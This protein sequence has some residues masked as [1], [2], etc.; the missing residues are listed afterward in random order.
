MSWRDWEVP[1]LGFEWLNADSEWRDEGSLAL[2]RTLF[3]Y[4]FRPA[5]SIASLFDRPSATL[6]RWDRMSSA[7]RRLLALAGADAHAR[8]GL[9]DYEERPVGAWALH[10]PAYE[11]VFRAFSNVV[12][13]DAPLAMHAASDAEAVIAAIGHGRTHTV[14]D[15]LAAGGKFEFF[16]RAGAAIVRSGAAVPQDASVVFVARAL[17]PPGAR[18]RLLRNGRVV[19]ESTGLELTHA[20]T[21]HLA[22]GEMGAAF[23]VEVVVP[24]APGRPPVPWIVSNP[25]FVERE[26]DRLQ[27]AAPGLQ[28]PAAAAAADVGVD[29]RGC[30]VEKDAVSTATVRVNDGGDDLILEFRLSDA[31]TGWVALACDLPSAVGERR[32]FAAGAVVADRP[33]RLKVQ[34]RDSARDAYRW[35][36]SRF[37][38]TAPAALTVP[39]ADMR[40]VSGNVPAD[41]PGG[42]RTLLLVVDRV[43]AVPGMRGTLRVQDARLIGPSS[44]PDGQ[45]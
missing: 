28:T 9:R 11:Q 41:V 32:A 14:I 15:G 8:L 42:A 45:Q 22:A 16:A 25:I 38:G 13:L 1:A 24:G 2:A 37:V 40:P 39:F 26:P 43:H 17:S 29:L 31:P 21:T 27:A 33:M 23:R 4:P 36:R 44:R 20:A 3:G 6:E 10:V 19:A 5:E 35:S 30:R 34:V 12:E 7:G 18:L